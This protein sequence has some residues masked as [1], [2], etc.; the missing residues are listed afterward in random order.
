M[1]NGADDGVLARVTVRA[2]DDARR[3]VFVAVTVTDPPAASAIRGDGGLAVSH[4]AVR[5]APDRPS[6]RR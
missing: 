2:L 1:A 4:D 6:R 3:S 5:P